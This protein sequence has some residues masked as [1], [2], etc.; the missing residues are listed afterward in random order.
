MTEVHLTDLVLVFGQLSL[1]AFGGGVSVLPEMQRQ[2]TEVHHWLTPADF[3][4]LFALAQA[5][6][7]PN[8]LVVVL[9][10][11]RV[12][13][14][15]GALV[16]IL[17]LCLPSSVLSYGMANL[18]DRFRNAPWRRTVQQ[19]IAPVTAGLIMAGALLLTATTTTNVRTAVLTV[20]A[21]VIFLMTKL[22]PLIVLGS[23]AGLGAAGMLR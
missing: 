10:G 19:G 17:S 22:H 21:T 23:A 20:V 18:W 5:S 3:A 6:P 9:I 7:G 13:G 8:M 16:A 2:V 14:I 11:W 15:A 4:S 1:L 12:S